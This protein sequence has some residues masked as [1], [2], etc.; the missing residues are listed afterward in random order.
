MCVLVVLEVRLTPP[1]ISQY[2][3][4]ANQAVTCVTF[5]RTSSIFSCS[6]WGIPHL[7]QSLS[8]LFVSIKCRPISKRVCPIPI[9]PLL[10]ALLD[11]FATFLSQ[12][13]AMS[14]RHSTDY[15]SDYVPEHENSD[16]SG[17][18][19]C[20]YDS[21]DDFLD[22]I[23]RVVEQGWTFMADPFAPTLCLCNLPSPSPPLQATQDQTPFGE[24][25][26]YI[27]TLH[28]LFYIYR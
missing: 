28:L 26:I 14:D 25:K 8:V 13:R 21:D 27:F 1:T 16:V 12:Y 10:Y 15:G 22:D 4:T 18:S 23:E 24:Y 5:Y 11:I 17:E 3:I 19:D 20:D 2:P 7:P 6:H 9:S